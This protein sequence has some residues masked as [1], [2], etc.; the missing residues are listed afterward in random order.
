MRGPSRPRRR[1][2]GGSRRQG[3]SRG[4]F[5][6]RRDFTGGYAS[7]YAGPY[8]SAPDEP[9]LTLPELQEKSI[10]ELR[11]LA[12]EYGIDA[13]ITVADVPPN[14]RRRAFSEFWPGLGIGI[15]LGGFSLG[16]AKVIGK[17]VGR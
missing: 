11:D 1:S 17:L 10:E 4:N 15:V 16:I 6:R 5:Q 3:G 2:D 12:T 8:P 7:V 14:L 13:D 9:A